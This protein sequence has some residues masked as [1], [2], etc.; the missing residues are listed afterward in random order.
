MDYVTPGTVEW[1][2]MDART[3]HFHGV[4]AWTVDVEW[5]A[6]LLHHMAITVSVGQLR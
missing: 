4:D 6:S 5:I 2:E 3:I 1:M